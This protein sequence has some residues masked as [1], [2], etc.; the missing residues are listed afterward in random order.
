MHSSQFGFGNGLLTIQVEQYLKPDES[1]SR[2]ATPAV[3]VR[4]LR[5]IAVLIE[6]GNLTYLYR[7]ETSPV[8]SAGSRSIQQ[9][10]TKSELTPETEDTISD[11]LRRARLE[12]DRLTSGHSKL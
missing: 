12:Q 11:E 9:A 8:G 3:L 7:N 2:S 5:R 6:E 10:L 1:L 4:L